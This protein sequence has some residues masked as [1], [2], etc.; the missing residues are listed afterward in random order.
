MKAEEFIL[1]YKPN[2][3]SHQSTVYF[4]NKF[5]NKTLKEILE[6]TNVAFSCYV[7]LQGLKC[8]YYGFLLGFADGCIFLWNEE[9]SWET[10][11][12]GYF[13]DYRILKP[14][15]YKQAVFSLMEDIESNFYTIANM[16]S[17]TNK[18]NNIRWLHSEVSE[19]REEIMED[20]IAVDFLEKYYNQNDNQRVR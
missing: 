2:W 11:E 12:N 9:G 13:Y 3:E 17:H 18:Q 19:I 4:R 14:E 6:E 20:K 8:Y 7:H 1:K 15:E 5:R 10:S 16:I